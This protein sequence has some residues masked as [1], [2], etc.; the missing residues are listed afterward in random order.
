M[1]SPVLFLLAG[2]PRLGAASCPPTGAVDSSTQAAP[3]T[4][5]SP[6]LT[7]GAPPAPARNRPP[8]ANMVSYRV[9][10]KL[11]PRITRCSSAFPGQE[12]T[13]SPPSQHSVILASPPPAPLSLCRASEL[14]CA[15][16]TPLLVRVAAPV[17]VWL[18]R[19][20]PLPIGARKRWTRPASPPRPPLWTHPFFAAVI[21][22][23]SSSHQTARRENKMCYML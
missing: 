14:R 18:P 23:E 13:P 15:P 9:W 7:L 3:A 10:R 16:A 8:A 6:R 20:L 4:L 5:P 21:L 22:C 1:L 11:S 17:L 19:L 2:S 12:P